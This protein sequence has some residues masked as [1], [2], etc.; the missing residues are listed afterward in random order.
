MPLYQEPVAIIRALDS[1]I[2][3]EKSW[4]SDHVPFAENESPIKVLAET[5]QARGF[6]A[7]AM[8]VERD[9]HFLTV[10]RALELQSLLPNASI[11]DFS[12]VMWEM[13][14]VKSPLEL[15]CLQ[16]AAQICGRAATAAF[17]VAMPGINEREVFAGMTSEA[18]RSRAD[19]AQ[20]AVMASEPRSG[21]L[22]AEIRGRTLAGGTS[23]MLNLFH[24]FAAKLPEY[25]P[26]IDRRADRRTTT[27]GRNNDSNSRGT[28]PHN[29]TRGLCRGRRSRCT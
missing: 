11:V 16:V 19:N 12:Q 3:A 18:W 2:F 27:V 7:S 5:V 20:I 9:S 4:F 22:H 1:A 8:G 28:I 29:E 26:E 21:S 25:A 24:I 15:A 6:G 13:R 17:A 14:Y 23:C 10:D